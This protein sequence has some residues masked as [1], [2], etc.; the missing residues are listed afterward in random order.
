MRVIGWRYEGEPPDV[1]KY[2]MIAAPHTSGLDFFLLLALDFAFQIDCVWMGKESLF[3][4]PLA[5]FLRKVGGISI[6]R[7]TSHSVVDQSIKLFQDNPRVVMAIA[8][9]GTRGKTK[10]WKTGFYH[11]AN[12]AG[13][14]ISLVFLDYRRKVVGFGPALTPTG[15]A[16]ADMAIIRDFYSLV[17]PKD[18]EKFG[19]V[20]LTETEGKPEE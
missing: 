10:R 14:P 8:P 7:S 9:E 3:R 16:E 12:G 13:V 20:T 1:D 15:D 4:G 17:V 11:I 6:D 5:P 19:D 2:V 18:L